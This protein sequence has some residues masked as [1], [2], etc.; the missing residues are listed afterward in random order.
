[1]STKLTNDSTEETVAEKVAAVSDA[2]GGA[3]VCYLTDDETKFV[4]E[5]VWADVIIKKARYLGYS[6]EKV[7]VREGK[8]NILFV[9]E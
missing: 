9:E 4:I 8:A 3:R 6:V 1:M 2:E 7:T 5:T